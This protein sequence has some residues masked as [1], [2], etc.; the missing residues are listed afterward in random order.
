M[1][2]AA[3]MRG[4][5]SNI[6][7]RKRILGSV[8]WS[9]RSHEFTPSRQSAERQL[10]TPATREDNHLSKVAVAGRSRMGAP[11]SDRP[12]N[13]CHDTAGRQAITIMLFLACVECVQ[14]NDEGV[15]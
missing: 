6:Q 1:D 5:A 9:G 12:N 4:H 8:L 15:M 2:V 13:N 3:A 7:C 10:S 11:L 14:W